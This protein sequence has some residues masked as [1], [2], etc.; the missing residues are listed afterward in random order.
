LLHETPPVP[1]LASIPGSI[2]ESLRQLRIAQATL[3]R[4]LSETQPEQFDTEIAPFGALETRGLMAFGML[5]HELHHR[6][7]LHALARV[8]GHSVCNLYDP[9]ED[10]AL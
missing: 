5:K 8:R 10:E 6:G 4:L 2:S 7:E 9:V 1:Q 3:Y